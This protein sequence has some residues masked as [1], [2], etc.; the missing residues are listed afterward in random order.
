M[1][2]HLF[3]GHDKNRTNIIQ[4]TSISKV[5]IV[6]MKKTKEEADVPS[7]RNFHLQMNSNCQ[8]FCCLE[9]DFKLK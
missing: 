1:N 5:N 4:I 6:I 9:K 3:R 7:P 2:G 8:K